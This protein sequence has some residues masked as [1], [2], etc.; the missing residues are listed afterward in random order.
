MKVQIIYSCVTEI[1]QFIYVID[2][3]SYTQFLRALIINIVPSGTARPSF[4]VYTEDNT[5]VDA[6]AETMQ[7]GQIKEDIKKS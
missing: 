2:L 3:T 4:V 6:L 5:S 1:Q 7:H